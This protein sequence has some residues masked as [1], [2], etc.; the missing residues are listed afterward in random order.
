MELESI[1]FLLG[2]KR[3]IF[4]IFRGATVSFRGCNGTL[5]GSLDVGYMRIFPKLTPVI[6]SIDL[7]RLPS[8]YQRTIHKESS[9]VFSSL[10][11]KWCSKP[12]E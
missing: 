2:A 1:N 11:K 10:P 5:F 6:L 8:S 7:G 12:G 3:P 9:F 4:R